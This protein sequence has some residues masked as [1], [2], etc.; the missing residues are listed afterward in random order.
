MPACYSVILVPRCKIDPTVR[1][2]AEAA[3][4]SPSRALREGRPAG[5]SISVPLWL[6]DEDV[7]RFKR[8]FSCEPASHL[9][10]IFHPFFFFFFQISGVNLSHRAKVLSDD[11]ISSI[12]FIWRRCV[13]VCENWLYAWRGG[14]RFVL[15]GGPQGLRLS[16]GGDD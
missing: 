10:Q 2:S 1:Q 11:C 6:S 9:S 13:C 14:E 12:P 15:S 3:E 8:L 5:R 4:S 7:D 16:P